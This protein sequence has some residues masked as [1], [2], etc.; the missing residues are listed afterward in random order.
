MPLR[1]ATGGMLATLLVGGVSAVA[2]K[3]DV[4]LDVNGEEIALTTFS[5]DVAGALEQAGVSI[6]AR[7]LVAPSPSQT[8]A[9]GER[10]TVRSAKQVAVVIDGQPTRVTSTALTVDE[11]MQEVGGQNAAS[12]LSA[13]TDQRIPLEGFTL[14][15]VTPKI[16]KVE[17]AG[18]V[19]YT[20]LAAET[21]ADVLDNEGIK[22]DGDDKVV[23]ALDTRVTDDTAIQVTKV[24]IESVTATEDFTPKPTYIDDPELAKGEEKEDKPAVP[25]K[26]DV[27][28]QIRK[29]N[30]KV[31][32]ETVVKE[33]EVAPATP[34]TIKRGTK[35]KPATPSV[36]SG[37]VWDA[38]AQCEA[39]GNWAINTGNGF[40][41]G[42]QFTPSTWLA[43][44]GGQY[45]PMAYLAS[46]E[47]Q[48]AVAEKVQAA[49]GWGAW[50]ACTSKM[51]LR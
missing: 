1:L 32:S 8:L 28:K 42:L 40:S 39:T 44:G 13:P 34:A 10:V 25:G 11:L 31:V 7:D 23:P 19:T 12:K 16:L 21:V 45:A 9:D 50:P 15:V 22:V 37:S 43:F 46:R 17:N 51:G 24:D 18:R 4:V 35:E 29:E 41:G 26:R 5:G 27:T 36:A 33:T 20:Q 14:D 3:K 2:M 38:L 49:Q 30:G 6:Q 47:E 48:I